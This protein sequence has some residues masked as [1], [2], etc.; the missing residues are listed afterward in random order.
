MAVIP[1]PRVS[2]LLFSLAIL[3]APPISSLPLK[4]LVPRSDFDGG[5]E[6]LGNASVSSDGSSVHIT[7]PSAPSSGLLIRSVPLRFSTPMSFSTDF[8][9]SISAGAGDGLALVL[10]SKDSAST[11]GSSSFGLSREDN[12]FVGV[13]FDTSMDENVGDLNAN[14]VGIDLGSFVSVSASN[15]SSMNLVLNSGEKLKSWVDYDASSK[16]L[17]VRLSRFGKPRPYIPIVAHLVDLSKR[18]NDED[19]VLIG[20]SSSNGN[21]VQ[22]TTIHSWRF[23]SR[24]VPNSL[25]SMP[26]NPNDYKGDEHTNENKIRDCPVAFLGALVLM[27]L[28]GAFLLYV[29]PYLWVMFIEA[30]GVGIPKHQVDFRYEKVGL[31]AEHGGDCKN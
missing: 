31:V 14:H 7:R 15:A 13:E 20:L 26:V 18:W 28:Y 6:L 22:T 21:S 24:K 10:F 16:R 8:T 4:A 5:I 23:R 11:L 30:Y 17:E 9:F 29:V 25:H 19:D 27:A 2:A 1:L 3:L 12:R